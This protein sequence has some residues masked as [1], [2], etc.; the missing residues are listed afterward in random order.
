MCR[1]GLRPLCH[2][3]RTHPSW[4]LRGYGRD[5]SD[6]A[7]KTELRENVALHAIDYAGDENRCNASQDKNWDT[8]GHFYSYIRCLI[9]TKWI[10]D[11]DF[12]V[13][14]RENQIQPYNYS[15]NNV[16]TVH[17]NGKFDPKPAPT[18]PTGP[19]YKGGVGHL[20]TS[21]SEAARYS[22]VA[23]FSHTGPTQLL[24]VGSRFEALEAIDTICD[25]RV[26]VTHDWVR[27]RRRSTIRQSR[28][29]P[30]T[31]SS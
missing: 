9:C 6:G 27:D 3:S 26:K 1:L 31:T 28:S 10:T 7:V 23:D 11:G 20:P 22:N 25:Q 12:Q 30:T 8:I 14:R 24:S 21:A 13:G 18:A 4:T 16:D 5:R 19:R 2:T 29:C 15:P 17:P